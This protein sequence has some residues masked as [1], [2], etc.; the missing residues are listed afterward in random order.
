[1]IASAVRTPIGSF[2]SSLSDV[3]APR[4]GAIAVK[5]AIEKAGIGGSIYN[6]KKNYVMA[7]RRIVSSQACSVI[8]GYLPLLKLAGWQDPPVSKFSRSVLLNNL[9]TASDQTDSALEG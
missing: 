2:R 7:T 8:L 6:D 4:L 5:A 1:M 3:P 9:W